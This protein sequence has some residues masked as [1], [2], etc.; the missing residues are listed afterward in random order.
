MLLRQK[1]MTSPGKI[2]RRATIMSL[3]LFWVILLTV[4]WFLTNNYYGGRIPVRGATDEN[5]N[6]V[7]AE[8]PQIRQK[9]KAVLKH[10][11]SAKL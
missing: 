6:S 4:P 8:I 1:I 9:V 10:S 11:G 5:D 7:L 3:L 2:F